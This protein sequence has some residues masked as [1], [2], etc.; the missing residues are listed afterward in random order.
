MFKKLLLTIIAICLITIPCYGKT[1]W[2]SKPPINSQINWSHPLSR[3]LVGCWLMNE[4]GGNIVRDLTNRQNGL[5]SG[6]I[7]NNTSK[8]IALDFTTATSCVLLYN[9]SSLQITN[10]I[11]IAQWVAPDDVTTQQYLF[12]K[13]RAAAGKRAYRTQIDTGKFKAILSPDGTANSGFCIGATTLTT[14]TWYHLVMVYNGVDIRCY[15]NGKLDSNGADNP[16]V[17]SSGINNTS[18][19]AFMAI[20]AGS[21]SDTTP[22]DAPYNGRMGEV[23]IYNRALSP[24]E[25]Q[26]LY[27]EPYC[28]I[29]PQTD[30]NMIK[31]AVAAAGGWVQYIFHNSAEE[32]TR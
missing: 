16:K 15:V 9:P 2:S 6:G 25:I 10:N 17:Y 22:L 18:S 1:P 13:W 27:V 31:A 20:G 28:F 30:W 14:L 4:G 19:H 32:A 11:T 12:A 24:S 8:G 26:Q 23:L 21:G 29:Q 5:N 7:W 3:G